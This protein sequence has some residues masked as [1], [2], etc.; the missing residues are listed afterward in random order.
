MPPLHLQALLIKHISIVFGNIRE[1]GGRH[2][3]IEERQFFFL[4]YLCIIDL[5]TIIG[6]LDKLNRTLKA[7]S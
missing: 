1:D 4:F 3:N 7:Q 6:S 5:G 2:N